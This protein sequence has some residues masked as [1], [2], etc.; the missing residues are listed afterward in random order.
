MRTPLI[1]LS[2]T[3]GLTLFASL[4]FAQ[5]SASGLNE[6]SP[7]PLAQ[8]LQVV[9]ENNAIIGN[10]RLGKETAAVCFVPF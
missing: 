10:R 4:S 6:Y 8:Y 9:K 1:R 7:I 3:L 2:A 5:S